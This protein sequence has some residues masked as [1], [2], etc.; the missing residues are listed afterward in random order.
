LYVVSC[1]VASPHIWRARAMRA[2]WGSMFTGLAGGL[3]ALGFGV[4]GTFAS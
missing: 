4:P 3:A 2:H 1:V